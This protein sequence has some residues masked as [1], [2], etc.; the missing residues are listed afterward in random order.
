MR[1]N[2][3]LYLTFLFGQ[4]YSYSQVQTLQPTKLAIFKNGSFFIKKTAEVRVINKTFSIA[5]PQNVLMG[6]YWLSTAN[7]TTVK[8]IRIKLDTV[9][10]EAKPETLE[11]YYKVLVGKQIILY[12]RY[13]NNET[14]NGTLL[15]YNAQTKVVKIKT[16]EGKVYVT[17]L[18]EYDKISFEGT[19]NDTYTNEMV[20][21]LALV[22]LNENINNTTAN[23]L[24]LHTGMQ[25]IPSYL[26]TIINDKEASLSLKATILTG[27]NAYKNTD[28]DIVVGN[29]EMFYGKELDPI[30]VNFLVTTLS[31][32]STMYAVQNTSFHYTTSNNQINEGEY[33]EYNEPEYDDKKG[34]KVE[35]LY[36]YKL[37]VLD[38]EA[39]A[40][41]IIPIKT[42]TVTYEDIYTVVLPTTSANSGKEDLIEV[43][44]KYRI[45]NNND[46]PLTTGSVL[47]LN[48]KE[49]PLSQDELKYTPVNGK[50]TIKLS[51]AID[52]PV[53]NDETEI[54]REKS[55]KKTKNG[56][57]Y[58][59]VFYKGAIQVQNLQNKKIKL[60]VSKNIIGLASDVSNNGKIKKAKEVG[61]QANTISICN[62]EVELLPGQ[63]IEL[64]Y[65]YSVLEK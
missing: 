8:S 26:L 37:G 1:K 62:W 40:K 22:Q 61:T 30:A 5:A 48:Q 36:I 44:H 15:A 18:E 49:M 19:G 50:Q 16:K 32:A 28:V 58:D 57:Y 4:L 27:K 47:V 42:F 7:N 34:E 45:V 33:E 55:T 35:D 52:V 38:L 63:K 54:K 17:K 51:K 29:P 65:N 12:D 3:L 23:T 13:S 2:I 56:D 31:A 21:P 25:W 9:K 39:N 60:S 64:T 43:D 24:S 14:I 59:K 6:T 10:M 53:S 46:A 41:T 11:D 20:E